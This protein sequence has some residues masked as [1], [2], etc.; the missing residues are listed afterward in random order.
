YRLNRR[1]EQDIAGD[2]DDVRGGARLLRG[3]QDGEAVGAR[4][5]QIG[6]DQD[7]TRGCT[8]DRGDRGASVGR[9]SH[10]E[11]AVAEVLDEQFPYVDFVVDD[12][13]LERPTGRRA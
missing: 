4:Q 2:D 10:F 7:E 6:H 13:H 3:A 8:L 5:L 11:S 1:I 9:G 12:E